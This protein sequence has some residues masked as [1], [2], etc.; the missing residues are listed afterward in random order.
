VRREWRGGG[1][2]GELVTRGTERTEKTKIMK[3]K[4]YLLSSI[5]YLLLLALGPCQTAP[6]QIVWQGR[7]SA[8]N[9]L[10]YQSVNGTNNGGWF[11]VGTVT[12]PQTA[13]LIQNSLLPSTNAMTNYI[14]LGLD[15]NNAT[16]VQTFR[17]T[18]TNANIAQVTV[19]NNT[20]TI[21]GRVQVTTTN[22]NS[23]GVTAL[24]SQ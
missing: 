21:Y 22:A 9:L 5:F 2:E 17:P 14:Q 16:T 15:T 3:T 4:F 7:Q 11:V 12:I 23:V 24:T 13:F 20:I 8:T 6:A 10:T 19:S 1:G 18:T